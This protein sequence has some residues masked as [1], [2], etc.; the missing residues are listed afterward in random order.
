M[1]ATPFTGLEPH[2]LTG[3]TVTDRVLGHGAYAVVREVEYMGLKCAGKQ[4]HG[5]L[6]SHGY[7]VRRFE[8]ECSISSRLTHP[9]LVQFLGVYMQRG[10][11]APMLI[12]EYLPYN[13]SSWIDQ[14]GAL[15]SEISYSILHDVA[16]GLCY[17]HSQI[18]PIVH[19]DLSSNNVLLTANMTAKISDLATA[20]NID[21]D[22]PEERLTGCPGTPAF[23]APETLVANP[24]YDASIDV[25]SYG[26]I[27]IHVF[28]GEWPEPQVP[29]VH[30]EPEGMLFPVSESE[31][32]EVFL[33]KIGEKHLLMGLILA[34]ISNDPRARPPASEVA[35]GVAMMDDPFTTYRKILLRT[36]APQEGRKDIK[37][38]VTTDELVIQKERLLEEI[39]QLRQRIQELRTTADSKEVPALTHP[40]IGNCRLSL[41]RHTLLLL[42]FD[43]SLILW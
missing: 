30:T 23:S 42:N 3:V 4:V 1:A 27:M 38:T 12:M 17:L 14:Y 24:K 28:S 36:D 18:P 25:F 5:E 6:L 37:G 26:I 21:S 16:L 35:R 40:G 33:K 13:L 7:D 22:I 41:T 39:R 34:C 8:R 29:A 15:K 32:R 11:L 19:R 9:N 31:R 43:K 10:V 20:R 2:R